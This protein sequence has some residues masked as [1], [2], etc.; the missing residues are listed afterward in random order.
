MDYIP[1]NI[2][3]Y[4]ETNLFKG[5]IIIV[6]GPR[7]VGKTTM[8]K[9]ITQN[10]DGV[11]YYTCDDIDTRSKLEDA[12]EKE[13]GDLI[14]GKKVI[15]I[16]E[17][18]LVSNIGLT[19]KLMHDRYPEVQIIASG[20]SSFELAN[21]IKEP[22]TGRSLEYILLPLSFSEIAEHFGIHHADQF[23]S[24]GLNYGMYPGI[25]FGEIDRKELLG[26]IASQYLYK[27]IL[28][29]EGLRKPFILEKILKLLATSIGNEVSYNEIANSLDINRKTVETYIG[30]LEQ[31]FIVYKLP[32]FFRNIRSQISKKQ[33]IFF[34]DVG[35][36]NAIIG[37]FND[38]DIRP[39]KG[40]LWEN[41]FIS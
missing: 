35:M 24:I 38:I 18:Q 17:A 15:V 23:I 4:I 33:K 27:D 9:H 26:T 30:Y 12:N 25:L 10:K 34:Y 2:E 6:Y 5:K 36:R 7:Q 22:L 14:K 39:D 16:D 1:R 20:S 29:F 31:A 28:K 13:V 8:I 11:V 19:L 41:F 40:A 3:K 32:P 21:K 37:L